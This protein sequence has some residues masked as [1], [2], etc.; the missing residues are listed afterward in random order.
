MFK[1]S[2]A[3]VALTLAVS[4]GVSADSSQD[5]WEGFNRA[6]FGFNDTV[7]TYFLKPVAKG[8]RAVTPDPLEQGVSNVFSNLG[9]VSNTVN[10]LL[11]L[12]FAQ[13]GND[14][15]RLIV[16]STIGIAGLF[17]VASHMG[18]DKSDGEDF[19]QTLASWGV[20]SGPYVVLPLLGPTTLRDG[21]AT[22]VEGYLTPIRYVDHVP[23]RNTLYG[24]QL[25]NTRASLLDAEGLISGDRYTFI[26][27][28]YLQNREQLVKDGDV[29]D[30]FGADDSEF[31]DF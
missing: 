21:V 9:E 30:S 2:S 31:D 7:D 25:V 8:Y 26:R 27:D 10:D 14:S 16:N 3:L 29:E 22:P 24:V 19:G 15:G 12:K 18:M 11:Q 28:V 1:I 20:D 13:A 6:M 5:P 17:D 23:T 4:A